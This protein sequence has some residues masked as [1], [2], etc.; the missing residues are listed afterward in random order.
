MKHKLALL[1]LALSLMFGMIANVAT[2]AVTATTGINTTWISLADAY[3][4]TEPVSLSVSTSPQVFLS[5]RVTGNGDYF[6]LN[7]ITVNITVN[8]LPV[9]DEVYSTY[10]LGN[11][12]SRVGVYD[13]N[14]YGTGPMNQGSILVGCGTRDTSSSY[15]TSLNP[16]DV[17][18]AKM[19]YDIQ[20]QG[21]ITSLGTLTIIP[22]TTTPGLIAIS[23]LALL[24]R[25]RK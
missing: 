17:W 10:D 9:S 5:F 6:V 15:T 8:G 4:G 7:S 1:A 22:E 16:G 19:T 3:L 23:T 13:T 20:G 25:K 11:N 2:A 24:R 14:S 12:W 18:Q 21:Q